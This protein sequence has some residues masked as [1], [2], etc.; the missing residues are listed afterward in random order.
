MRVR[1]PFPS[2]ARGRRASNDLR[3]S[4]LHG[5][6]ELPLLPLVLGAHR[7]RLGAHAVDLLRRET[8]TVM[9]QLHLGVG[10][11][12]AVACGDSE[13]A[14]GVHLEAHVDL[15]LALLGALHASDLELAQQVVS[16][17]V[18]ALA[19]EDAHVDLFL[20]VVHGGELGLLLARHRG[21]ARHHLSEHAPLALHAQ[22]QGDHVH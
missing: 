16:V 3:L 9:L 8:S 13:Q 12:L 2:K 4:A 10:A 21:V 7:L 1:R 15:G 6:L 22:A 17:A 5:R 20:V 11:S 19:L 14:V 18:G